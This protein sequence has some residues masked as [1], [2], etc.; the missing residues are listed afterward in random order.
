MDALMLSFPLERG[1]SGAPV[2]N[3]SGEVIGIASVVASE[4]SGTL[5]PFGFAMPATTLRAWLL[6]VDR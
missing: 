1:M 4:Q 3:A 2:V 5:A 6:S